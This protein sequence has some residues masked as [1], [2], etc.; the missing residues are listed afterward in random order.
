MLLLSSALALTCDSSTTICQRMDVI[1]AEINAAAGEIVVDDASPVT[2]QRVH[3]ALDALRADL[4]AR[5]CWVDDQDIGFVVGYYQGGKLVGGTRIEPSGVTER[6][7]AVATNPDTRT[8]QLFFESS[9]GFDL[10]YGH[11]RLEGASAGDFGDFPAEPAFGRLLR[12]QG[13]RGVGVA[14]Y[15]G[16]DGTAG[17]WDIPGVPGVDWF[18]S[19]PA[20]LDYFETGP[21]SGVTDPGVYTINRRLNLYHAATVSCAS[22]SSGVLLPSDPV[23]V[24]LNGRSSQP[25]LTIPGVLVTGDGHVDCTWTSARPSGGRV[26]EANIT[27]DS[28]VPP[29]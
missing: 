16:C 29:L 5:S 10:A 8:T 15:R 13:S 4:V 24:A 18:T 28:G 14:V 21:I 27:V 3:D 1:V 6:T 26:F 9:A 23:E 22:S 11:M 19:S 25:N 7:N 20:G 17:P 12:L 2:P